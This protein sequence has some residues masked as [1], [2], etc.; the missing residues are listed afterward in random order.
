LRILTLGIGTVR[1]G[2]VKEQ[3]AKILKGI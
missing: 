2:L 1:L 3:K